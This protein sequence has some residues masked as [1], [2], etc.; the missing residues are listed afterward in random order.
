VH[1]L[2]DTSF[3]YVWLRDSCQG[4]ASVHP[5]TR[6]KLHRT[7]DVAV[8]VQPAPG[9]DSVRV[10]AGTTPSGAEGEALSIVWK[11]GHE[12]VYTREFLERYALPGRLVAFHGDEHLRERA[13]TR[14]DIQCVPRLFV[15]YESVDSNT[16]TDAGLLDA[17]TQLAQ[18]GILFVRGVPHRETTN[19]TCELRRLAERFGEIR[20][21]FYGV[22]WDVVNLRESRNIAYTNLDLGLHMDL[23]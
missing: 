4:A 12:S 6:Q 22:L 2:G 8:D 13:W 15:D 14:K 1:T 9:V 10:N 3:P 5:G 17:M 16:G 21:T 7:S 18:Y 23:L 19:E 20:P 11:D